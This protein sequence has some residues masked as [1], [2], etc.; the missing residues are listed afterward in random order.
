M[1]TAESSLRT[2]QFNYSLAPSAQRERTDSLVRTVW[3]MNPADAVHGNAFDIMS[4]CAFLDERIVGYVGVASWLLRLWQG[5]FRACGLSCV[6]TH[7][8]FRRQGIGTRLVAEATRWIREK[9]T[10]DVGLFTCLPQYTPFYER[11]GWW[12]DPTLCLQGNAQSTQFNSVALGLDV[13]KTLL[14]PKAERNPECFTGRT[15]ALNL[16]HGQFI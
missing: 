9:S 5:D 2:M 15:L 10:A 16:P 11:A 8:K 3:Q 13:F 4:F 12:H 1:H 6:C 7:S 14:T